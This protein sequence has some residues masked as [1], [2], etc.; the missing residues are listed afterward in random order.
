MNVA[1]INPFIAA[2]INLFKTMI[3]LEVKPGAPQVKTEGKYSYDVSGII[4]FSGDAQG[5]I[6]ISFPKIV[7]LKVVSKLLGTE[8]KVV[9]PEMADGIGEIANIVAGNAKK[10]LAEFN[11]SISLPN[12]VVGHDHSLIGQHGIPTLI[13]PFSSQLGAFSLE[14]R[15]KTGS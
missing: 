1:Y 8:I 10:D 9:G 15:M 2:T 5:S 12:V 13:V 14:V 3:D 6:A 7:A 4:G 11:L